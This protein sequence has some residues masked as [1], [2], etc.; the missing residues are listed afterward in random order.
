[1]TARQGFVCINR[2]P[3]IL[4]WNVSHARFAVSS[5][6]RKWRSRVVASHRSWPTYFLHFFPLL[7]TL[8]LFI[9]FLAVSAWPAFYLIMPS[10]TKK[11]AL[12]AAYCRFVRDKRPYNSCVLA[13]IYQ[14]IL[15]RVG[16]KGGS[17]RPQR[18]DSTHF[19]SKY[20]FDCR[21]STWDSFASL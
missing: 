1:M 20:E 16:K 11:N 12:D 13:F 8:Y 5:L 14:W 2:W 18:T 9:Y 3:C 15:L 6:R 4:D 17:I 21:W 7:L 19:M 10:P